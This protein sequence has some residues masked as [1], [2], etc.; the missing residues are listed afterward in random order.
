MPTN[1]PEDPDR[2]ERI[3]F[4]IVVDC[5]DEYERYSGWQ[6]YLENELQLPFR[7]RSVI[8]SVQTV[9][10]KGEEVEVF[11]ILDSGNNDRNQSASSSSG[12]SALFVTS[13][14][15][16]FSR[17]IFTSAKAIRVANSSFNVIYWDTTWSAAIAR[18][19]KIYATL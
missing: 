2:E 4:E 3:T 15:F 5:Y 13:A 7:A 14:E 6:C 8:E 16:P 12:S 10:R 17:N 19:R 9:L 1:E 18:L 11:E